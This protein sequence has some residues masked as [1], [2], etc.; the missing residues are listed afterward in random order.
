MNLFKSFNSGL[1]QY[2]FK[3]ALPLGGMES[4]NPRCWRDKRLHHHGG[5]VRCVLVLLWMD[6][7]L[8]KCKK[9]CKN[10]LMMRLM[11]LLSAPCWCAPYQHYICPVYYRLSVHGAVV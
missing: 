4:S 3:A 8:N 9:W 2:M 6:S 5:D 10:N 7:E 1:V 11:A